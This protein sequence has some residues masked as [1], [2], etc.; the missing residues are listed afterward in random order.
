MT[1]ANWMKR[2]RCGSVMCRKI[3]HGP[4]PSIRAASSRLGSS[5]ARPV[6]NSM[7]LVPIIEKMKVMPSAIRASDSL[8]QHVGA[9]AREPDERTGSS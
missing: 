5:V 1:K 7:V 6:R 3:R 4:A 8:A 2:L 9:D